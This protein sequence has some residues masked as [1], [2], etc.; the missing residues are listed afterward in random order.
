MKIDIDALFLKEDGCSY[1]GIIACTHEGK[2]FAGMGFYSGG[3]ALHKR[4]KLGL[5]MK[6]GSGRII[7]EYDYSMVAK[8]IG[9][10]YYNSR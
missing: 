5:A 6:L 8:A 2:V 7:L 9:L 3:G 10:R 4:R 1:D